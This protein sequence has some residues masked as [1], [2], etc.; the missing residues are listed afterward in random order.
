MW[1]ELLMTSEYWKSS[2]RN[3]SYTTRS[4][5]LERVKLGDEKAWFEFYKKYVGM[6]RYVG[7][8]RGLSPS[9]CDDLMVEVMVIFWKKMNSFVYDRSKGKFRSYLGQIADFASLKILRKKRQNNNVCNC[10][11]ADYPEDVDRNVMDEWHDFLINKAMEE[12]KNVVDTET[13]QVFYMSFFQ[14]RS[15]EE[16]SAITRK[17]PNNIYVI[18]SRCIKKLKNFIACYRLMDEDMLLRHSK[19]NI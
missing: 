18:R 11:T 14:K 13:Y 7:T 9:E 8:V 1:G 4:S 6:I 15:I 5:F 17:T 3:M 12:L 10:I 2:V 16:I 19:R